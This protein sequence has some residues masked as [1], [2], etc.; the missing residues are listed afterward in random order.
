MKKIILS[1]SFLI[2][3]ELGNA[4]SPAFEWAKKMGGTF[5][6]FGQSVSV[7]ASGNV[8]TAG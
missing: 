2:A 8:Y 3:A 4:Q 5:S 6:D 7:D 1:I